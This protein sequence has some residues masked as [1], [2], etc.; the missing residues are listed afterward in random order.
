M[1]KI[2]FSISFIIFLVCEILGQSKD[3]KIVCKQYPSVRDNYRVNKLNYHFYFVES[4]ICTTEEFPK[5]NKNFIYNF[6]LGNVSYV[7]PTY[8]K[9][10]AVNCAK[11]ICN[12]GAI[13]VDLKYFGDFVPGNDPIL[14]VINKSRYN[15]TNFTL[16]EHRL[17]AGKVIRTISQRGNQFYITSEGT[18]NN[19]NLLYGKVNASLI[20]MEM[21]W[22]SVDDIFIK[23]VRNA[24]NSEQSNIDSTKSDK[25][26]SGSQGLINPV[27]KPGVKNLGITAT[28]EGQLIGGSTPDVLGRLIIKAVKTNDKKLYK[29]L[30]H[31]HPNNDDAS[32]IEKNF[33]MI[34]EALP[35]NGLSDWTLIKFS[36]VTFVKDIGGG[37]TNDGGTAIN[38][39]QV[40]RAF[41]IEFSYKSEF[42]GNIG[43]MTIVTYRGKYFI[44]SGGGKVRLFRP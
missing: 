30:I 37:Y 23:A 36:R 19:E 22:H 29:A 17:H 7:A 42:I 43:S 39:E 20:A 2:I 12:L 32:L 16:P 34:R 41:T 15:I 10:A 18:G 35:E 40:R 9:A 11:V 27:Q 44:F 13:T 1:K 21:L 8:N 28:T 26:N 6:L 31:P 4:L 25:D 38:G 33:D 5:A 3:A 14:T 24:L